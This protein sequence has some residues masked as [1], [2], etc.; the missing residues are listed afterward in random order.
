VSRHP[1]LNRAAIDPLEQFDGI[2]CDEVDDMLLQRGVGGEAG[3]LTNRLLRLV[4]IAAAQ[5]GETADEGDG[6]IRRLCRHGILRLGLML[7]ILAILDR[8]RHPGHARESVVQCNGL[9]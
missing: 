2:A 8:D 6:I 4:G 5:F 1:Q 7:A 9:P 3:S